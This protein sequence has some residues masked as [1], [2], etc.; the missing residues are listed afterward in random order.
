MGWI[1]AG[2]GLVLFSHLHKRLGSAL[3]ASLVLYDGKNP[4]EHLT[5]DEAKRAL[6]RKQAK[7]LFYKF[8][9]QGKK[10]L[11]AEHIAHLYEFLNSRLCF[12]SAQHFDQIY[13]RRA[14]F[15]A[16]QSQA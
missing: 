11:L 5:L 13:N 7:H 12:L 16:K 4:Y 9:A 14:L 1:F 3:K 2:I 15:L 10:I 8:K 6:A